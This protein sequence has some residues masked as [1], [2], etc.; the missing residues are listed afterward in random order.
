MR[1][2]ATLMFAVAMHATFLSI[3]IFQPASSQE[4]EHLTYLPVLQNQLD[5]SWRWH[6][7]ADIVLD[8]RPFNKPVS[9]SD[10]SGRIHLF[11]DTLTEPR[12]IYHTVLSEQGWAKIQPIAQTIGTSYLLYPPVIS[13]DG[14]LHF[15]WRNWLGTGLENPYRLL[16]ARFDGLHWNAEE[17]IVRTA[18][19]MQAMVQTGEPREIHVTYVEPLFFSRIHQSKRTENGWERTSNVNPSHSVSLVWPDR[20][21]GIH[22]YES[23]NYTNDLHYSYWLNG[24]FVIENTVFHGNLLGHESQLDGQNNLHIF[25]TG[26]VPVVGSQIQGLYYQCL[27]KHLFASPEQVLSGATEITGPVIKASDN[28]SRI[29]LAWKEAESGIIQLMVRNECILQKTKPIPLS[30]GINWE[31]ITLAISAI[32][33]NTCILAR[34]P[35]TSNYSIMC[36]EI[37]D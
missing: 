3:L 5:V 8:P 25:W 27:S 31:P 29:A 21:G 20:F 32:P 15:V 6:I 11:W 18:Y 9:I 14:L 23:Y 22:L 13:E 26:Q 28:Q 36:A 7:Q 35:Y 1:R 10:R 34:Q 33:K 4:F 37:I 16:Y 19:E 2:N 17:E 30:E 24:S 12:L